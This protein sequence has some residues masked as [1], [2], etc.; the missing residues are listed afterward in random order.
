MYLKNFDDTIGNRNLPFR[1]V[2]QCLKQ[3]LY[4]DICI[5][6]SDIYQ[7][8]I[9]IVLTYRRIHIDVVIKHSPF[10]R[11][12]IL[13]LITLLTLNIISIWLCFQLINGT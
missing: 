5:S 7:L 1:L 6:Q 9:P 11:H 12:Y 3:D 2:A 10:P 4:R 8:H 13:S